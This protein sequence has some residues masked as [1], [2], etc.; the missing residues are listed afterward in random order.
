MAQPLWKTVQRFLRKINRANIWFNN[1]TLGTY[2]KKT[3]IQRYVHPNVHCSTIYNSQDINLDIIIL[4]FKFI[5]FIYFSTNHEAYGI[6]APW[7]GVELTSPALET[8][9]LNHQTT[10]KV[11]L[12]CILNAY[13]GLLK[14]CCKV[15]SKSKF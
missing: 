7:R 15:T 9:N 10:M 2:P 3:I 5:L 13:L 11:P 14:N 12:T 8:Q 6:L 1:P 4:T